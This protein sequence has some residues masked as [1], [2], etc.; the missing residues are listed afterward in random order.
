MDRTYSGIEVWLGAVFWSPGTVSI[1][2]WRASKASETLSAVYK[3]E[4]VQYMCI[5][6]C[7]EVHVL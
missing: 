2:Y 5:Y 1:S 6:I 4:L 7:M 3:F